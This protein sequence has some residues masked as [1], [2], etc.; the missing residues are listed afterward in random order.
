MSQ[1]SAGA[2]LLSAKRAR[3]NKNSDSNCRDSLDKSHLQQ[4]Q[5]RNSIFESENG[6]DI[7]GLRNSIIKRMS[8]QCSLTNYKE[9]KSNENV[10][11]TKSVASETVTASST[12]TLNGTLNYSEINFAS[13]MNDK[14]DNHSSDSDYY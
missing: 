1:I 6:V 5:Q 11:T 12:A 7:N 14:E 4:Q 13:K 9:R 2:V 10:L 3:E 8:S